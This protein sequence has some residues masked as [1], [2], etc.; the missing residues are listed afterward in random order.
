MEMLQLI[1]HGRKE[2][3]EFMATSV[4]AAAL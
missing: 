3:D 4:T 2:M 1:A